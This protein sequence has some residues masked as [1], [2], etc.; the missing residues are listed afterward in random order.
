ML[1][2]VTKIREEGRVA[3]GAWQQW[4]SGVPFRRGARKIHVGE[5]AISW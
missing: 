4:R 2:E 5:G 1:T 3:Q